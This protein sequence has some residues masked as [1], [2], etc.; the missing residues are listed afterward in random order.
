MA[1]GYNPRGKLSPMEQ[2]RA[3]LGARRGDTLVPESQYPL[4][5]DTINPVSYG[6]RLRHQELLRNI[7]ESRRARASS[8]F[9]WH[10]I[11]TDTVLPSVLLARQRIESDRMLSASVAASQYAINT[12][13]GIGGTR[14][15]AKDS[16]EI[17]SQLF[18]ESAS[19]SSSGTKKMSDTISKGIQTAFSGKE[20]T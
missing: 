10:S 4:F 2:I 9:G 20:L 7:E 13:F 5:V 19:G 11:I 6:S 18:E 16:A 12:R 1:Y 8:H 15:S 17:L 14:K 3:R